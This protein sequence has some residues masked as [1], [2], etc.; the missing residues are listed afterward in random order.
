ML[1][2]GEVDDDERAF[3]RMDLFLESL[4]GLPRAIL[5][6]IRTVSSISEE[7]IGCC[8]M[9]KTDCSSSCVVV[10]AEGTRSGDLD[11]AVVIARDREAFGAADGGL[12][13]M[14]LSGAQS[15]A[16]GRAAVD[17]ELQD[18]FGLS[19]GESKSSG[20]ASEYVEPMTGGMHRVHV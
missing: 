13:D 11:A 1:R 15:N 2:E 10:I 12:A 16:A 5:G 20:C 17:L 8:C 4:R 9:F 7:A 14:A 19:R 3:E 18:E 6:S